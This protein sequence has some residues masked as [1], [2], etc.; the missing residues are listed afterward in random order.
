MTFLVQPF[1]Y[2]KK[3][4]ALFPEMDAFNTWLRESYRIGSGLVFGSAL[5]AAI[6]WCILARNA[7]LNG[8]KD[9]SK[10][11]LAWWTLLGLPVAGIS[12]ALNYFSGKNLAVLPSLLGFYLLD[13]AIVYWLATILGAPRLLKYVIPGSFCFYRLFR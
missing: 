6:I 9:N 2:E 13:V 1:I 11:H 8:I 12:V 5:F 3:Q 7:K 4:A 10:L